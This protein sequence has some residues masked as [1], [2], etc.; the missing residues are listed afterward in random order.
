MVKSYNIIEQAMGMMVAVEKL[1]QNVKRFFYNIMLINY[2]CPKCEGQLI[3]VAEGRC[4][5]DICGHE[6]DP[7]IQFQLCSECGGKVKIKVRHYQCQHCSAG[8][9]SRFLFDGLIFDT[10]YFRMKVAESRQRKK[11]LKKRVRQM[12]LENRSD[13]LALEA[14]D[15]DSVPGLMETLNSLTGGLDENLQLEEKAGF[16]L[17][18]YQAHIKDHI[19]S[20]PINFHEIPPL[21]EDIRL[22]LIWRFIAIIFMEHF[23]IL[24]I[25]QDGQDIWVMKH[26]TNREGQD[27]PGELEDSDGIQGSLGGVET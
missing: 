15:L 26:E 24:D 23:R 5:C 3:M 7:T 12:L 16:D 9:T 14:G 1:L 17:N 8:V 27:L 20:D 6:F 2:S 13:T 19:N 4:R 18:Q 10:D 11:N 25:C 21:I 22:D